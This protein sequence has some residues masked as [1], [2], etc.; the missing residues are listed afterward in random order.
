MLFENKQLFICFF[1]IKILKFI[2][3]S[4][5]YFEFILLE[6]KLLPEFMKILS[7]LSNNL[8]LL[9]NFELKKTI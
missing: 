6:I 8:I 2:L 4:I 9:Y 5:N 3:P 7:E 1:L